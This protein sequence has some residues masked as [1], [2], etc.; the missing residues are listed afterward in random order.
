MLNRGL[1]DAEL[2]AQA[3]RCP[4]R[5]SNDMCV[6]QNVPDAVT[7]KEWGLREPIP[8]GYFSLLDLLKNI[9]DPKRDP[10]IDIADGV[11]LMDYWRRDAAGLIPIV[12]Q[13]EITIDEP[14]A[15]LLHDASWEAQRQREMRQEV[16]GRSANFPSMV[17]IQH[18]QDAARMID[19]LVAAFKLAAGAQPSPDTAG[20][21]IAADAPFHA[22]A[23][24]ME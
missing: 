12:T 17:P 11:T 16:R 9:A 8:I 21:S 19:R 5:G 1:T 14:L 20:V 18:A 4:C 13:G 23:S 3:E 24:K 2:K 6:C 22:Q 15:K 7:R 10:N